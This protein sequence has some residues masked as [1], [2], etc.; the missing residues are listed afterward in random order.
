MKSNNFRRGLAALVAFGF[1]AAACGGSDSGSTT[2]APVTE[3]P[4]TEA[5]TTET[6]VE[7]VDYAALGLWDDGPCDAT[8][9]ELVIGLQTV[10][11]SAVLTLK[12]QAE[13][14]EAAALGFNS[15]GGANGHCIKIVTCDDAADPNKA[16]E[17][18]RTLDEAGIS[19]TLNDTTSVAGADVSAGYA[20]AGIA[21]FALSPGQDDYPDTNS[22]P[23]GGGGTGT[24]L[25]MPKALVTAGIK[26][27]AIIRVDIPAASALI[28]LFTTMYTKDGV[29]FVADLPVPAGT[30]DYSQF[31]IAAQDAGAEGIVMPLG[32]QEAIQVVNAAKQLGSTMKISGSMGTFPLSDIRSIGD[33]AANIILNSENTPIYENDAI[34]AVARAD[35]EST[36]VAELTGANIKNS[37]YRS[38]IGLYALLYILR[39]AQTE[40]F[41]RANIKALIEASG[42]IPML[43][44]TA[45]WTPVTNHPGA[46]LRL[47]NGDY[48][49]YQ[50]DP[51]ITDTFDGEPG[52]FVKI[53]VA[54][55][56]ELLCGT[57][58]G[59][60]A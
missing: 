55:M 18:V 48:R 47:G 23:F 21:R 60:C 56:D 26:K 36:G 52:A 28:G 3:A 38:W 59:P 5:P 58:G 34:S 51:T 15:R 13:S 17:C 8:K 32:G 9:E 40:D 7:T 20:A 24:T 11:E 57:L 44:L 43:G 27:I 29:E 50:L 37:P 33:Y 6:P 22:Y 46:W 25:M 1:L 4:V 53:G 19:V 31:I 54:D 10:F 39:Q 2:G 12:D 35:I 16:V 30:T 14:L 41:S 42:V 45:D 49:F